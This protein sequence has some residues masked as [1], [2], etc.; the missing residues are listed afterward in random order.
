V[1][2]FAKKQRG[3]TRGVRNGRGESWIPK[4]EERI[5]TEKGDGSHRTDG[6][7]KARGKGIND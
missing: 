7:D 5:W 2:V 4:T 6:G 3:K 1:G